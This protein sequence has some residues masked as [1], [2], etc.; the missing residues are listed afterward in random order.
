MD[1]K[2]TERQKAVL[3]KKRKARKRKRIFVVLC[4]IVSCAAILTVIFKAPFFNITKIEVE[5]EKILTKKQILDKADIEVGANIF[6]V[7]MSGIKNRV[8]TLS[9]ADEVEV[10][11]A[12]PS[13]VKITVKECVPRAY[14]AC[15]KKYAL[16]DYSGKILELSKENKKYNV[17]TINGI[18]IQSPVVGD[19]M[20]NEKDERIKNCID[21]LTILEENKTIEKVRL[22]DFTKLTGIKINYDDRVF[23]NCG[24][25][26][27]YDDFKYKLSL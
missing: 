24:S 5:G 13:I 25:F 10:K 6:S 17:M 4:F 20:E 27:S 26:D 12:F 16:I 3:R 2:Y 9:Y 21:A 19:Y 1:E 22:L 7:S 14:I 8:K 23:V 15:G 11:R 18:K